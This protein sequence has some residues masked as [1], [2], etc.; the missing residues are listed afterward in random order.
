MKEDGEETENRWHQPRRSDRKSFHAGDSWGP[1]KC[2][3]R[4]H[5]MGGTD[6]RPVRPAWWGRGYGCR[7]SYRYN[8][9][10]ILEELCCL[11][12]YDNVLARKVAQA[13]SSLK[14]T[15]H[16][17]LSV[18][19]SH[20][21]MCARTHTHTHTHTH[22][23]I[24]SVSL[25]LLLMGFALSFIYL[26]KQNKTTTTTNKQ[27]NKVSVLETSGFIPWGSEITYTGV[28]VTPQTSD[29][30]RPG[31]N[32]KQAN[33]HQAIEALF[34]ST[35]R[36]P[37]SSVLPACWLFLAC[38]LHGSAHAGSAG[39]AR[40]RFR[41][42]WTLRSNQRDDFFFFFFLRGG[43]GVSWF[44]NVP[45]TCKMYLRDGSAQTVLRATTLR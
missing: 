31:S 29:Y 20:T 30:I 5:S 38:C 36:L 2:F 11:L 26:N 21:H 41:R 34:D 43:G 9:C 37:P 33:V 35:A 6:P 27:T 1:L 7:Y 16:I 44:L 28:H 12:T 15:L 39:M 22:T 40:F 23:F 19:V 42:V 4:N 3:S 8:T 45:N 13:N 17:S 24:H 32:V 25:S 10:R 18:S 14:Y